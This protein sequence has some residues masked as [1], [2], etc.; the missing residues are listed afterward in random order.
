MAIIESRLTAYKKANLLKVISRIIGVIILYAIL[1]SFLILFAY[2]FYHVFILA[3]RDYQTIY[4][5]PP[6]VWFG[7]FQTLINNWVGLFK[8]IPYHLNM[9]NSLGIA[10]LAT[11][12]QVFFCTMAGFAFQEH[13]LPFQPH[14]NNAAAISLAHTHIP[15]DGMAE[16][17]KHLASNVHSANRKCFWHFPHDTIH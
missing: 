11:G 17:D 13:T 15:D 10:V 5:T 12:T 8:A 14:C 7:S 2:P 9:F 1:V 3:T 6:P 16:M 4:T